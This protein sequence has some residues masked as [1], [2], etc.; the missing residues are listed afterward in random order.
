MDFRHTASLKAMLKWKAYVKLSGRGLSLSGFKDGSRGGVVD[1][2]IKAK[3]VLED[4]LKGNC[5]MNAV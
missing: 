5:H 2:S 1:A 4:S 3:T